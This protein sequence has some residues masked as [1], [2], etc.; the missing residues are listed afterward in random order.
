MDGS[1]DRRRT[2]LLP[3]YEDKCKELRRIATRIRTIG[4]ETN[5]FYVAFELSQETMWEIPKEVEE[6]RE[7]EKEEKE[8]ALRE[9]ELMQ[10]KRREMQEELIEKSKE[11]EKQAKEREAREKELKESLKV[12][13]L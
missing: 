10:E 9:Q 13:L 1:R 6:A 2:H 12:F 5:T 3:Q 11:A 8:K 7:K 4:T